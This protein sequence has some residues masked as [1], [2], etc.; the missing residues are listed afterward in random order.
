MTNSFF[1]GDKPEEFKNND[2][3]WQRNVKE[4]KSSV[5]VNREGEESIFLKYHKPCL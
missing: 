2:I 5:S 1:Q 3:K 4:I